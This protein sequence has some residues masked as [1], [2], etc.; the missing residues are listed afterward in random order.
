MQW[1]AFSSFLPRAL[2]NSNQ[3][4]ET[5]KRGSAGFLKRVA[6]LQVA[7]AMHRPLSAFVKIDDR[8][9]I[10]WSKHRNCQPFWT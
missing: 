9:T 7:C 3:L 4:F 5:V 10:A 6:A 1:H 2:A 8:R